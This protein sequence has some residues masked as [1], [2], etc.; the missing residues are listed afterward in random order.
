MQVTMGHLLMLAGALLVAGPFVAPFLYDAAAV[1]LTVFF[2]VDLL[3]LGALFRKLLPRLGG[4]YPPP[5][6]RRA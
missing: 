4:A 6:E 2:G 3:I 1:P 5:P